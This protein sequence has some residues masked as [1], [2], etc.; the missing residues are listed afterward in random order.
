MSEQIAIPT[1]IT[2][3][4]KPD[5]FLSDLLCRLIKNEIIISSHLIIILFNLIV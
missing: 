1:K 4:F 3:I 5:D 2:E